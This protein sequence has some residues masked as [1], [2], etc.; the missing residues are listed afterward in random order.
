MSFKKTLTFLPGWSFSKTLWE[1]IESLILQPARDEKTTLIGWS[2]GGLQAIRLCLLE[3][4]RY[5][6][7]ILINSAPYFSQFSADYW[8]MANHDL[9]AFQKRFVRWIFYPQHQGKIKN[10]QEHFILAT[11]DTR[12][13]LLAQLEILFT[14]HLC[15]GY[16][17]LKLPILRL[18]GSEDYIVSSWSPTMSMPNEIVK[19]LSGN[20]AL[21]FTHANILAKEISDFL[22]KQ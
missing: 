10:W 20:H 15:E 2:L 1:P 7:L 21:P 4:H 3:P 14:T 8:K 12:E 13:F 19:I 5:D 11:T 17:K 16:Q 18:Q 22:C 6:R 9:S